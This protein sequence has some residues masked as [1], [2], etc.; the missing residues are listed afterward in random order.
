[1]MNLIETTASGAEAARLAP[2][3]HDLYRRHEGLALRIAA[4]YAGRRVDLEDL[5]QVARV[6]LLEAAGC[7]DL[8]Y[9]EDSFARYAGRAIRSA[10]AVELG[11]APVVHLGVRAERAHGAGP[12]PYGIAVEHL[13]AATRAD[14]GVDRE[15]LANALA[16]CSEDERELITLLYV[17]RRTR[18]QAAREMGI[19]AA[20]AGTLYRG[21]IASMRALLVERN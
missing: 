1:M 16:L 9:T 7:Y 13:G 15:A 10:L 6:A 3:T 18:P 19:T 20:E 17:E 8:A 2:T 12:R 11:R 21:A 14:D 4:Q 5:E